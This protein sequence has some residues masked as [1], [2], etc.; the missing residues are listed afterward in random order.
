MESV[1]SLFAGIKN[2]TR[3]V[4][5][6]PWVESIASRLADIL[7]PTRIVVGCIIDCVIA[8]ALPVAI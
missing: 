6:M 1:S 5:G 2:N 7:F 4:V 8:R 3:A